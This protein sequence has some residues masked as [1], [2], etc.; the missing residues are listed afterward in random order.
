MPVDVS[1]LLRVMGTVVALAA[2]WPAAAQDRPQD[3]PPERLPTGFAYLRDIDATIEQDI[4]YAGGNNFVGRPLPG[5][6]AAECIL[7][8]AVA[9]ALK[10]VQADLAPTGFALKVYDCYRP[11]RAV[12][13]MAQWAG[14][15]KDESE[16]K[17]FFPSLPKRA[18]FAAGYISPASAHSSGTAVDITMVRLGGPRGGP[19]RAA[20]YGPCTGTSAQRGADDSVD[21]GTGFD[22]LDAKSHTL[23]PKVSDEQRRLRSMLV[24]AMARHGFRNYYREWWHFT[25]SRVR[26]K[27]HRDFPV[28]PR[29]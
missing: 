10:R 21:M 3:R 23:S 2:A 9:A 15:G 25:F 20:R 1:R 14:D 4:R 12:R 11:V 27:A 26:N 28:R 7:Q 5:Y 17:R 8:D 19:S 16:T 29:N 6:D 22:C 24:A 13:A 18:L